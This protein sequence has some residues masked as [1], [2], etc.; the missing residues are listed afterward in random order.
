MINKTIGVIGKGFVGT[1][2]VRGFMNF[3]QDVLIYDADPKKSSH[4]FEDTVNADF[5]F[6]CLPTP[7]ENAE[8][9]KAD[10]S[11]VENCMAKI[12]PY[13]EKNESA[14]LIKSTVP[15]GTTRILS[16]KFGIIRLYHNPEFLTAR[17]SNVDFIT[18]TRNI[19]GYVRHD[20]NDI[21]NVMYVKSFFEDRFPGV[22]CMGMTSDESEAVKYFAN[23]FFAT[24]VTFFNEIKLLV[25][26]LGL[27]WDLII[28]GVMA[29]GRIGMSH[30]EVPGHDNERG[31]GGLCFP[32]D[33]NALI[34]T[35]EENGIDPKLL[36]AS[37]E[38]NKAVREN[39]DWATNAS[40]VS[41]RP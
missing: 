21:V 11:I 30:Y 35:M 24:K 3:V 7:M 10:L 14:Y 32:K 23:C 27:D 6:I 13:A 18:P 41:Q 1:A 25:D 8:G 28:G 31:Y 17:T 12:A 15:I 20:K 38:Q 26:K 19:I 39:W 16:E 22:P 37:W 33:I 2:V 34:N 4:S 5:V 36:K 9:G 29:D 40:A